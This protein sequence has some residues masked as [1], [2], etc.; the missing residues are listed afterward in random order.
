MSGDFY[1]CNGTLS[2]SRGNECYC[3]SFSSEIINFNFECK[4][5]YVTGP[6]VY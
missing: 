3:I 2:I 6:S 5:V 1:S 4:V